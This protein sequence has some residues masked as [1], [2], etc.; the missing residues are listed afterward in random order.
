MR[1]IRLLCIV[2]GLVLATNSFLAAEPKDD[3]LA[4][5]KKLGESAN[6]S[7]NTKVVVPEG[8][9]FRPGPSEGKIEKGGVAYF[10]TSFN[11]NVSQTYVQGEKGAVSNP[12]GGWQSLAE[13][14]NAEGFARFRAAFA[15]NFRPPAAQAA[16]LAA[17]TRN[18]KQDGDA[19]VGELTEDGA[20][21]F[22]RLRRGG[23]APAISGAKGTV[24]FWI[25]DGVLSKFEY[26]VKGSMEFNGNN[27]DLD[28][29]TTVEIKDVGST[30]LVV[31][32]DVKKKL[33]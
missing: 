5:A 9:Q 8:T 19:Y 21:T 25:K 3:V 30:K 12:D 29:I 23:D 4:A 24:K 11:D 13:L 2:L 17:A 26:S 7:W 31:P 18:L 1:S 27:I 15:R 20:K 28:R 14:D 33:S 10:T 6:Y 22:L 16:E 32:D